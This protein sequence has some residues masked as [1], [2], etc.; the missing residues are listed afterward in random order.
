MTASLNSIITD[1]A[2]GMASYVT[3]NKAN[4]NQEGVFPD[5]T[6]ARV[7]QSAHRYLGEYFAA[8]AGQGARHRDDL[9]R[10][11]RDAGRQAPTRGS[12]RRHR[13]RRPVLDD[14]AHRP[15]VLMGG[16]RKWFLPNVRRRAPAGSRAYRLRVA[17]R[18]VGGVGRGPGQ[19]RPAARPD[20]RLLAGGST[21]THGRD[22]CRFA[23]GAAGCSACSPTRT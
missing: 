20:R 6:L 11:R 8:P 18:H 15:A 1:S 4:N 13:H 12:R 7:R 16:G 3:G 21:P 23:R 2:P 22:E 14:G 17:G 5:D 19:D 10:V 9:R